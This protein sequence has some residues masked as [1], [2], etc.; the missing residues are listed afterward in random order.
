MSAIFQLEYRPLQEKNVTLVK[1]CCR[2][3]ICYAPNEQNKKNVPTVTVGSAIAKCYDK[4]M[5]G[6]QII[7]MPSTYIT[8]ITIH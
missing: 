2:I 1:A 6:Q 8:Y 7:F 4:I 3:V 5:K